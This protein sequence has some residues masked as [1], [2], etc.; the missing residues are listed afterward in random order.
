MLRN[1]R[2]QGFRDPAGRKML[3]AVIARIERL[4]PGNPAIRC[5]DIGKAHKRFRHI[6]IRYV[7]R[8]P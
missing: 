7:C 6:R 8:L 4:E 5:R 3:L 2:S 1:G